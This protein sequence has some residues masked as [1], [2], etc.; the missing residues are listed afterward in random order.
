MR[1]IYQSIVLTMIL[2]LSIMACAQ[3]V[4]KTAD[5]VKE[6]GLTSNFK[7][8]T[9]TKDIPYREG[10]SDSWKLDLV[11]CLQILGVSCAQH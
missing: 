8:I 4:E 9:V 10:E 6:E 2:V 5:I 11:P 7:T 3:K 1:K